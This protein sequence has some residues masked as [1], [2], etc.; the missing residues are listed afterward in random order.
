MVIKPNHFYVIPP[1]SNLGILHGCL[2]LM[3]RGDQKGQYLPI[4]FFLRSLAREQ[5]SRKKSASG[6]IYN[7]FQ[8]NQK[9]TIGNLFYQHGK[10]PMG[11]TSVA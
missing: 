10:W 4:D 8:V 6:N 9:E 3:P 1:N 7:K 2:H 5:S 11:Y